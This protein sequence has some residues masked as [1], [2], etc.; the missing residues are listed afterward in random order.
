MFEKTKLTNNLQ[1]LRHLCEEQIA[2]SPLKCPWFWATLKGWVDVNS[3][4]NSSMK[5]TD[6]LSSRMQ[7]TTSWILRLEN[8]TQSLVVLTSPLYSAQIWQILRSSWPS[9]LTALLFNQ[10]FKLVNCIG[11]QLR[12]MHLHEPCHN[13]NLFCNANT[14]RKRRTMNNRWSIRTIWRDGPSQVIQRQASPSCPK[15]RSG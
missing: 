12:M 4:G 2:S 1:T 15:V 5:A 9:L 6:S 11:G 14:Q 13:C 3:K 7:E 8:G 10:R